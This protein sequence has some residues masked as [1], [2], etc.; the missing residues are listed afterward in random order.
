MNATVQWHDAEKELP[1]SDTT[2]LIH[3]PISDDPVWLGYHDGNTW[4][5]DV[6]GDSFSLPELFVD[7]WADLPEPPKGA[8]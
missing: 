8:L 4:W 7:H 1:D 2:V 3:C 6:G 5:R